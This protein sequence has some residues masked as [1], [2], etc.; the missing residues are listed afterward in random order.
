MSVLTNGYGVLLAAAEAAGFAVMVT[1]DQEIPFP[2]SLN[3]RRILASLLPPASL[4][5]RR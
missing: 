2:Q 4:S 3:T 1:T 5:G